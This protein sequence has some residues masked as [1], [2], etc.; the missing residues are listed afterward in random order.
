MAIIT[1][2]SNPTPY[3][4][5]SGLAIK[6]LGESIQEP[7]VAPIN[8][9]CYCKFECEYIERVFGHLTSNDFWKN[10]NNTFAFRRLLSTDTVTIKLFK[11]GVE[12]ATI[13]DDTYGEFIDG[14]PTGT[15]EQQLYVVFIA[16]WQKILIAEGA[17]IYR[18]KTTL[19]ILGTTTEEESQKFSLIQ[20]SDEAADGTVRIETTQNGN[21][22]GST[23]DFT[24]LNFYNSYRIDGKFTETAPDLQ[25]EFYLDNTYKKKQ[26]QDIATPQYALSTKKVPRVVAIELQQSSILANEFLITDFNIINVE[27][28]R[29]ISVY[30]ESIEKK[31]LGYTTKDAFDMTFKDK[32]EVIRKRNN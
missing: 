6:A 16:D 17:G 13:V 4:I 3:L 11:D 25:Q 26:I 5:A 24:G 14:Y 8:D 29:R 20:Y 12:V 32:S 7:T 27:R 2:L 23:F 10:D 21:I 31:D 28:F 19:V 18:I 30:T 15:A 1:E 9:F 22:I